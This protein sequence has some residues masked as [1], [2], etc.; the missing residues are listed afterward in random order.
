MDSYTLLSSPFG[1]LG[2]VGRDGPVGPIVHR[3]F[4]PCEQT[5]TEDVARRTFPDAVRGT[6]EAMTRLAQRIQGFLAGEPRVF[7]LSLIALETCPESQHRV[8]RSE[9]EIPRGWV[10]NHGR[11]A[12]HL[13]AYHGEPEPSATRSPITP[14]PSLSPATGPFTLTEDWAA[15][16]AA[17]G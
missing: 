3:V 13:G 6:C 5:L 17:S 10:S 16:R 12:R 14:S 9:H 8:L 7:E 15:S 1:T 2:L 11:I 4:L